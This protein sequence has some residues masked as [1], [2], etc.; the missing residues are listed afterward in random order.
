MHDMNVLMTTDTIGGVW[1][2][3]LE[4]ARALEAHGVQVSLATLGAPL[5][6]AQRR[7]VEPLTNVTLFESAY[8]LEWMDDPWADV[9]RSGEWLLSL[10]ETVRPDIVHLNGYAHGQLPFRAPIVVVGHSCV[11][12]WWQAVKG[13]SA[14]PQWERYRRETTAGLHGADLVVAPSHA[15]LT[16][17]I[18]HYGPFSANR[19]IYNARDERRYAPTARKQPIILS[20]GR[21]WDEAKNLQALQQAAGHVPWPICV[22]GEDCHPDGHHGHHRRRAGSGPLRMLGRLDEEPLAGWLS[23]AAIYALPAKYEPF[24]LSILEAALS[25]CA[26]VLGDIASLREI[27]ADAAV[28]VPPQDT[29]ALAGALSSLAAQPAHRD[30]L[31]RQALARAKRYRPDVMASTYL[32]EYRRLRRLAREAL[33]P[34]TTPADPAPARSVVTRALSSASSLPGGPA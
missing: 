15:M 6:D 25:G 3:S 31:A 23:R 4:L 30:Q 24:G 33:R 17:L 22:A 18:E 11:L 28:Y 14:P 1:T 5:S 9:W 27:W 21:L 7:Q 16:A 26:L 34:A 32:G 12:S 20:A 19:V 8:L 13:A 29:A 2:Y 10:E